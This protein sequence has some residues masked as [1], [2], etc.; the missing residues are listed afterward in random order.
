MEK[1]RPRD[2]VEALLRQG[3]VIR[4]L[5]VLRI[6]ALRP[7]FHRDRRADG[8]M[9]RGLSERLAGAIVSKQTANSRFDP[10][11]YFVFR[12]ELLKNAGQFALDRDVL[13]GDL[14]PTFYRSREKSHLAGEGEVH[15]IAFPT[16]L[17]VYDLDREAPGAPLKTSVAESST[18]FL[19]ALKAF[20]VCYSNSHSLERRQDTSPLRK[21][22]G[23]LGV[24]R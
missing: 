3:I 1:A 5:Q 2:L 23:L 24:R 7:D 20:V 18:S 17:L 12:H 19:G 15:G 13:L 22:R 21:Y 11:L 8:N 14:N 10:C 4:P 6:A 16:L 9:Y